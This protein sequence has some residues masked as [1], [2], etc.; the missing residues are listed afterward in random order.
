[1]GK[2]VTFSTNIIT[3][4]LV[5]LQLMWQY[6]ELATLNEVWKL[7]FFLT[8]HKWRLVFFKVARKLSSSTCTE[9]GAA[10]HSLNEVSSTLIQGI[11]PSCRKYLLTS[12]LNSWNYQKHETYFR[13]QCYHAFSLTLLCKIHVLV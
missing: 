10:R 9:R 11:V 13:P 7:C 4:T 8:L 6:A 1:M 2:A 12:N 3:K 5:W